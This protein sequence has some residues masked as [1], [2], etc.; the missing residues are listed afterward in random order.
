[1]SAE[2]QDL[3]IEQGATYS[4][5]LTVRDYIGDLVNLS[6]FS[7]VMQIRE[8]LEDDNVLASS[9]LVPATITLVLSELGT[10]TVGILASVTA[11]FNFAVAL[12]DI[13]LTNIITGEVLRVFEGEV[14]LSKAVSRV[15]ETA[16]PEEPIAS[17][18]HNSF[19]GL[20]GGSSSERY[21]L[22]GAEHVVVSAI[23][24]GELNLIPKQSAVGTAEGTVFYCS[25][26]HSIYVGT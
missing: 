22:T 14:K 7:A 10:I 1:M 24:N 3:L 8:R 19:A 17:Y 9:S 18:Q 23:G 16:P 6:N 21:H 4:T 25:D 26:D 13:K 2:R 5:V 12:Y 15:L 20:Q 11:Y